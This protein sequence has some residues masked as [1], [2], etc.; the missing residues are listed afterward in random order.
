MLAWRSQM[1][2]SLSD[3]LS[4]SPATSSSSVLSSA[5]CSPWETCPALAPESPELLAE[6]Q[7]L[8][9]GHG[10]TSHLFLSPEDMQALIL[11]DLSLSPLRSSAS[12]P[13]HDTGMAES[14]QSMHARPAPIDTTNTFNNALNI[15]LS[16]NETPVAIHHNPD[17]ALSLDDNQ[18]TPISTVGPTHVSHPFFPRSAS[19]SAAI[20]HPVEEN[21]GVSSPTTEAFES[22]SSLDSRVTRRKN[23]RMV[24][25][26]DD[27]MDESDDDYDEDDVEE[28]SPRKR[29]MNSLK[30]LT[31]GSASSDYDGERRGFPSSSRSVGRK[32]VGNRRFSTI[33]ERKSSTNSKRKTKRRHHCPREGCQSSF[34][35]YTDMER[36][37]A[38]VHRPSD[39]DANRCTFCHKAF[40]R[41]DAVLRHE[42]DSCPMRPKKRRSGNNIWL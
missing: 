22:E 40:S 27:Y 23:I 12:L 9:I 10:Q 13:F 35:R 30:S 7:V 25:S 11:E 14:F 31:D 1:F 34:T 39:T 24:F 6:T 41:D 36:H 18:A 33:G 5:T 17:F 8:D 42:N 21:T 15:N 16:G 3:S 37:L 38:T 2:G 29:R 32:G 4:D 26:D 20:L 28:D 19:D